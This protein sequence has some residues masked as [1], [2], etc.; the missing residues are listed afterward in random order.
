[1]GRF[2]WKAEQPTVLQQT[3]G[4]FLG[5]MGITTSLFAQENCPASQ[6]ECSA[7]TSG[8]LPAAPEI[9]DA[10]RE[11]IALYSS[12][13]ALPAR[14]RPATNV[15]VRK[16]KQLFHE[17]GCAGC[18]VPSWTTS[19]DVA[20]PELAQQKIWP[21]TDLLLH[22]LGTQLSDNRPVGLA[23]GAD[24]RT[25]PL[26]GLGHIPAVNGHLELLHDGRAR[27]FAEAILW[28]GGE[29]QRSRDSFV[30]LSEGERTL[31]VKFLDSL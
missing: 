5:D 13:L 2:G 4:A 14:R 6:H 24:W 31:L 3:A 9:D 15:E 26:W 25:A 29:A 1:M 23:T 10:R 21:Y 11:K 12:T 16:G 20:I 22:D 30:R 28:H 18:H 17:S 19:A 8:G 27:G 7:K